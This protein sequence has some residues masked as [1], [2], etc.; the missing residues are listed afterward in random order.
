MGGTVYCDSTPGKGST[1]TVL[2]PLQVGKE[3]SPAVPE[4]SEKGQGI[5]QGADKETECLRIL[6]A[7]DE[8]IN[9]LYF[10]KILEKAGY[11]VV[12]AGN[13][14]EGVELYQKEMFD[15]VLMDLGLPVLGGVEA[16]KQIRSYEQDTKKER[17]RFCLNAFALPSDVE[18]CYSAGLDDFL[19]KPSV[20]RL[21]FI[22]LNMTKTAALD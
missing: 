16:A 12:L 22:R 5:E 2:L 3:A 11:K 9:Q 18:G 7:E 19:T 20:K 13:G 1:F 10:R 17:Y 15:L 14:K 4:I 21:F 8:P 6:I